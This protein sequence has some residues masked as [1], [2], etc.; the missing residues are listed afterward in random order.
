MKKEVRYED[1]SED[2]EDVSYEEDYKSKKRSKQAKSKF[3]TH[4]L[5]TNLM[6][7]TGL[8]QN[9]S[10]ESKREIDKWLLYQKMKFL[11]N[12]LANS[13]FIRFK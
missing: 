10:F 12:L 9:L 4:K 2:E 8:S 6:A 1:D 5:I 3:K 13:L 11:L 7:S